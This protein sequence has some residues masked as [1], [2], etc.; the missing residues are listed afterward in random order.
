[1]IKLS[2]LRSP[3][4]SARLSLALR[5]LVKRFSARSSYQRHN[6]VSF[7]NGLFQMLIKNADLVDIRLIVPPRFK[8][9]VFI[10]LHTSSFTR[11]ARRVRTFSIIYASVHGDRMVLRTAGGTAAESGGNVQEDW[12][13]RKTLN[14]PAARRARSGQYP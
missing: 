14:V 5:D 8:A 11:S 7:P 12:Q 3:A 6:Y 13:T 4:P 9:A 2:V 10:V 1:M